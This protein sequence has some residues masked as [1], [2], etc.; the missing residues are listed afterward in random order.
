MNKYQLIV[1]DK[2]NKYEYC[3]TITIKLIFILRLSSITVKYNKL[4]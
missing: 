3:S 2:S 1:I 4:T